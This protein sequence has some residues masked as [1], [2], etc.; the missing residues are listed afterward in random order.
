MHGGLL[1]TLEQLKDL[2]VP[3]APFVPDVQATFAAIP[4]HHTVCTVVDLCQA[5]FSV[6]EH[7][8]SQPL[9]AFR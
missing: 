3:L 1:R 5:S 7:P 6:P 8:D 4:V 2:V 9:C